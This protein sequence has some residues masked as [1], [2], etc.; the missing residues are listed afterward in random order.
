MPEEFITFDEPVE[1]KKLLQPK[2]TTALKLV[3][4]LTFLIDWVY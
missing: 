2:Q 3:T 4:Y 1:L